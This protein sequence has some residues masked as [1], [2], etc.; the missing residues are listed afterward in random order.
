MKRGY[1]AGVISYFFAVLILGGCGAVSREVSERSSQIRIFPNT[2][3]VFVAPSSAFRTG[4]VLDFGEHRISVKLPFPSWITLG[5]EAGLLW[6]MQIYAGIST[7]SGAVRLSNAVAM[8]G[9]E[10]YLSKNLLSIE[11]IFY[12]TPTIGG[13]T[14][15]AIESSDIYQGSAVGFMVGGGFDIG[16]FPVKSFGAFLQID[17]T[18]LYVETFADGVSYRVFAEPNLLMGMGFGFFGRRFDIKFAFKSILPAFVPSDADFS[19]YV[20]EVYV[21]IELGWKIKVF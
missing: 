11:D 14:Y 12:I 4:R 7:V 10:V 13:Q 18:Y 19:G 15:F 3:T 16:V 2:D 20:A 5:Y 9:P 8:I 1:L 6:D 21:G 17:L